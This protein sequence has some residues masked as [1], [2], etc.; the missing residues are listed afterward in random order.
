M[1]VVRRITAR[2]IVLL[3]TLGACGVGSQPGSTDA[4]VIDPLTPLPP[5]ASA[6]TDRFETSLACAQCH[7]GDE[8]TDAMRDQSGRDLS[9]VRLWR[10]SMMALAA[11]DPYYLAAFSDEL[12]HNPNATASV[13]ATCTRC[14]APAGSEFLAASGRHLGFDALVGGDDEAARL[15]REGVTCTLCHQIAADSL[16]SERS[17]SGGFEVDYGREIFGP[18]QFPL[19][20]PMMFFVG[21]TPTYGPHVQQSELCATC[22]TVIVQPLADDGSP[23]GTEIVEQAT[24]FE[25]SN[26][27]YA[28]S[29]SCQSC[30]VP[31]TDEDGQTIQ[32]KASKFPEQLDAREPYGRHMFVGGNAYM[33][34]LMAAAEDWAQ[35]GV[36]AA[37][38]AESAAHA[39]A[40]LETAAD[41]DIV[42]AERQGD[43]LVVRV[44]V[45]NRAGHKL[46]TG[47][48]SRRVWLHLR[49]TAGDTVFESGRPLPDGTIAG[50]DEDREAWPTHLTTITEPAQ[51]QV[52][53]A[54]LGDDSGQPTHRALAA[55]S[56]IKDN[57]ILPAGWRADGPNATRTRPIGTGD[58]SDFLAGSDTV[59]YRIADVPDQPL[60]IDVALLYQTLKPSD[61]AHFATVSTAAASRFSELAGSMPPVPITLTRAN[62]SVP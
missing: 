57:R 10:G 21:Y 49:V 5:P 1:G 22:H 40:H 18:Y 14:H 4:G 39:E 11:R 37:D 42:Q 32:T 41:V 58:D 13:E 6:S 16:G 9:P 33:L 17:F 20:D 31:T 47:Y 51:V 55:R 53:Q 36:P 46:P 28:A 25:W 38:L 50:I 48:P 8:D 2:T 24:Y 62:A 43:G 3:A 44:T 52:Y 54:I 12:T 29:D 7:L 35:H 15:G 61:I 26:S 59:E 34:R 45:H 23:A 30:H 27:Q 56:Y 60:T 19:A